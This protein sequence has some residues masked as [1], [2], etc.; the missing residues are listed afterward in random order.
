MA[1]FT[2]T[3]F[4]K[5]YC[6]ASLICERYPEITRRKAELL[7]D[8]NLSTDTL[9]KQFNTVVSNIEEYLK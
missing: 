1:R 6:K 4:D 5:A 9:K 3:E 8:D 7:L 2:M